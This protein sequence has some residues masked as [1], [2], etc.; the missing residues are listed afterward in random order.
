MK[1][2]LSIEDSEELESIILQI[3]C[4]RKIQITAK[5]TVCQEIE[6]VSKELVNIQSYGDALVKHKSRFNYQGCTVAF[7][8][9][10]FFNC[11]NSEMYSRPGTTYDFFRKVMPQISRVA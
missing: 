8:Y 6:C 5:L 4:S 1:A 2:S 7:Q 3:K 11:E 9:A 10:G